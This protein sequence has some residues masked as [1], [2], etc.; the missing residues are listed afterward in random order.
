MSDILHIGTHEDLT[1]IRADA[2]VFEVEATYLPHGASPPPHLHPGQ[3]EHF[4][5]LDGALHVVLGRQARELAAGQ[6]LTIPRGQVHRMW[7]PGG[8]PARVRWTTT[9]A[10][11]T[12]QWFRGLAELQRQAEARG[13][14]RADVL[15]F[16]A[17][18]RR[19]RDI[20]RLVAGG[21]PALGSAAVCVLGLAAQITRR[22]R[23][24]IA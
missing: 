7:N 14:H 8:Q 15:G 11:T 12:E 20:F 10:L 21:S 23:G 19:H 13:Q 9:P 17:H 16:A 4:A 22:D 6:E 5:V 2:D 1:V 18:A 24:A 3:D